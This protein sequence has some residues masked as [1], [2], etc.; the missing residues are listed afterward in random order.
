MTVRPSASTSARLPEK[1]L[2]ASLLMSSTFQSGWYF[3]EKPHISAPSHSSVTHSTVQ[4]FFLPY[5]SHS[6]I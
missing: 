5:T 6:P 3:F 4:R 2:A 1:K